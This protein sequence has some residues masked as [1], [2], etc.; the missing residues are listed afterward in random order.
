[1]TSMKDQFKELATMWEVALKEVTEERDK[2]RE[3]LIIADKLIAERNRLLDILECREHGQCVPGAIE[4]VEKMREE[5]A[6]ANAVCELVEH[7][8][9]EVACAPIHIQDAV[10][11]W[12]NLRAKAERGGEG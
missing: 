11:T 12:R 8:S 7:W 2:A 4:Q 3:E 10:K 5:L 6:A 1:M 9:D